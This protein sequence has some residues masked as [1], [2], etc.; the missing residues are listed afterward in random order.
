MK[1]KCITLNGDYVKNEHVILKRNLFNFNKSFIV[2]SGLK[3]VLETLFVNLHLYNGI[4]NT[5]IKHQ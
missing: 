2:L 5:V 1:K 4:P 3:F